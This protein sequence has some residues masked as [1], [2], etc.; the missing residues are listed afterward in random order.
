MKKIVAILLT[1]LLL[2]TLA[3]CSAPAAPQEDATPK[4]P[5]ASL[6]QDTNEDSATL[7][8]TD[9]AGQPDAEDDQ[10]DDATGQTDAETAKRQRGVRASAPTP[11][12]DFLYT[13]TYKM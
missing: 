4:A 12:F 11:L 2:V 1:C 5:D 10:N 3:G 9:N 7:P 13:E 6:S 8:K